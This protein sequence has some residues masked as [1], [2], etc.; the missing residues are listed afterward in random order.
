MNQQ[1]QWKRDGQQKKA[2]KTPKNARDRL[3][4]DGNGVAC[5]SLN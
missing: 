2:Q 1:P 5:E 4:G 3:D